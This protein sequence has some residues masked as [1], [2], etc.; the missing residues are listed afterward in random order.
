[1]KL[2]STLSS[3]SQSCSVTIDLSMRRL[4]H[5]YQSYVTKV[6]RSLSFKPP[7]Q[8]AKHRRPFIDCGSSLRCFIVIC[9]VILNAKLISDPLGSFF[10]LIEISFKSL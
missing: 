5:V 9:V 10:M 6:F 4:I 2:S 8:R 3:S 7:G 1:M